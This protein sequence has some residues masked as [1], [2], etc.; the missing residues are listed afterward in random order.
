M[1]MVRKIVLGIITVTAILAMGATSFAEIKKTPST[2]QQTSPSQQ[3]LP[4]AATAIINAT[5]SGSITMGMGNQGPIP[6]GAMWTDRNCSNIDVKVTRV[7]NPY[8]S[9]QQSETLLTTKATG[10]YISSGCSYS[11]TVKKGAGTKVIA[12]YPVGPFTPN[13]PPTR[14][15]CGGQGPFDLNAN[16]TK[17]VVMMFEGVNCPYL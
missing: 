7:T 12:S 6:A 13:N 8:Q 3:T 4:A 17:N 10:G 2:M 9:N 15:I 16:I 1:K 5:I 14:F 11:V